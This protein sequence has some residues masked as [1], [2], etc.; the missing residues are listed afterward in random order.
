M[1]IVARMWH[2]PFTVNNPL[3]KSVI[4]ILSS[5]FT[6]SCSKRV[7]THSGTFHCDEALAC[8]MLHIT[9]HFSGAD[10]VRTRDPKLLESLDAV[11]DVGGAYDPIRHRYDHHQKDFD[12]FFGHGFKTKLS[13]AGLVYKVFLL[14]SL[15]QCFRFSIIDQ[16]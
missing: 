12:Q 16:N 8:F 15:A 2:R 1:L 9:E 6:T 4:G 13:S 11:V 3:L 14:C 7:G 5:S 10:I